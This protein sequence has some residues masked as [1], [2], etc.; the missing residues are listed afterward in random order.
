MSSRRERASYGTAT[1][2]AITATGIL[3]SS[4]TMM[5]M[6][7]DADDA[8]DP[9]A[10]SRAHPAH[11]TRFWFE[12]VESFNAK[13]QGDT[14]GHI[15]RGGGLTLHPHVALADPVY[16]RIGDTEKAVGSVTGVPWDRLRGSL[17]VE[18]RAHEDH[19]IAVGDQVWVDLN[20]VDHK[21]LPTAAD[22]PASG[23]GK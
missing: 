2:Y 18:S 20:P 7:S 17:T 5:Q 13:Y 19:R 6:R 1:L 8:E 12:V 9:R 4:A 22:S 16:H 10:P 23:A 14:A 21:S 15:G 3:A 11:G